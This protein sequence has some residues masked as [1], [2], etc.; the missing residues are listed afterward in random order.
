M[1]YIKLFEAFKI[2][3]EEKLEE[4]ILPLELYINEI[5]VRYFIYR[6]KNPRFLDGN[7]YKIS[8]Y[9]ND[10]LII[11]GNNV[12]ERRVSVELKNIILKDIFNDDDF[13][14]DLMII[15]KQLDVYDYTISIIKVFKYMSKDLLKI[16]IHPKLY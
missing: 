4:I 14:N 8:A 6:G 2:L 15:E 10:D 11:D 13:I 5:D 7:H 12:L 3:S 1:K 9:I 16:V